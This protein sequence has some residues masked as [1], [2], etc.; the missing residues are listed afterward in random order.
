[1]SDMSG[2]LGDK[3]LNWM[4]GTA[5]GTAPVS[6]FAA[7]YNG[8]PDAA[9]TELTGTINLTRQAVTWGAVA[10]RALANSA[11]VNF[12]TANAGGSATYV[13]LYDAATAG[14]ELSKKLISTASITSGEKVAIAIGA[15]T[16]SY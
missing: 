4:K 13:V 14:N 8:D 1:M 6:V 16:L 2:Y 7:L 10:T 5:F 11:E 12:G 15:L 9:G 3:L